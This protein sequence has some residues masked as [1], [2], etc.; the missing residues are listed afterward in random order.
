MLYGGSIP[1]CTLTHSDTG[2]FDSTKFVVEP[3]FQYNGTWNANKIYITGDVA[4]LRRL[5]IL[6]PMQTTQNVAPRPA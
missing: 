3:G 1:K 4:S 6:C 2:T 5:Y